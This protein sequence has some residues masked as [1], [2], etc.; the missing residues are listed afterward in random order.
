MWTAAVA[1][2]DNSRPDVDVSGGRRLE[3]RFWDA[4]DGA[5]VFRAWFDRALGVECRFGPATDGSYRCVPLEARTDVAFADSA[6]TRLL[7]I[8]PACGPPPTYARG[9][10]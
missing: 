10:P 3:P 8:A 1:C 7:T 2:G 6:C 9:V 5:R 4:G